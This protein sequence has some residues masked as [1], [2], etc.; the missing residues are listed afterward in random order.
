MLKLEEYTTKQIMDYY[1]D[2]LMQRDLA[3]FKSEAR[4]LIL[5]ALTYNVVREAVVDQIV[6]LREED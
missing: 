4:R 2:Y 6:F 1:I 5:N 3:A